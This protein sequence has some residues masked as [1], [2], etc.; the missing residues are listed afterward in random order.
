M[1]EQQQSRSRVVY[2]V[3]GTRTPYLKARGK[4]GP[5]AASDLA[6]RS[7]K[8]LFDRLPIEIDAIDEVIVGCTMPSPDEANIARLIGLRLGMDKTIPAYTVQRNCASGL[9]ALDNA[10]LDI[11]SG[12]ADIVLAG[13]VE[14]M[15]RAPLLFN[16]KMVHFFAGMMGAKTM[17][18]KLKTFASFRP[19]ML[20][21]VIA[22][23]RGLTDPL[24]GLSMGKTAE[25]V[26]HR[27]GI[28][29]AMMDA[30]AARSH[31]RALHAKSQ[32][33]FDDEI[34]TVYDRKGR[35]HATDDGVRDDSTTQKLAKLKPFFDKKFGSVTAANSSQVTD[36]ACMLLLASEEAVQKHQLPVLAKIKDVAWAGCEPSQMGLGPVH[37][38]TPILQRQGLEL[39]DI[40]YWELNEAFAGQVIGCLKAWESED[41]CKQELGLAQAMGSIDEERLNVDGG[42]IALGHP[43][44]S[45]GARIVLHLANV[46]KREGATRGV[47]TLC[48][49]GGQ[50]G[51]MLIEA[52]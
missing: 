12:R 14:A 36:G 3:D 40:D 30:F 31:Q 43:V 1:S 26:A 23:M 15:S 29:R 18:Q 51:A 38:T 7:G 49:G 39:S 8:A 2:L 45:S 32:G 13:G 5:F 16:D 35:F 27:F 33:Y 20:A 28:T 52:A 34:V 4:P 46:L 9:Q 11:Q 10:F 21:P 37:A 41:Y 24:V 42:A 50:G 17:G 19:A 48:I 25:I 47:A 22:L 44:G 6:V